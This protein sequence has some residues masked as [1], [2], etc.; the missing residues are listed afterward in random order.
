MSGPT[1]L[2]DAD[3]CM[4]LMDVLE[5]VLHRL[6]P[7]AQFEFDPEELAAID[8]LREGAKF[9]LPESARPTH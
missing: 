2:F 9:Y 1:T 4:C 7:E 8:K 6:D 3:E 5:R